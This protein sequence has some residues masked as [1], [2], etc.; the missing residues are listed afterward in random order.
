MGLGGIFIVTNCQL[1]LFEIWIIVAGGDI[2]IVFSTEEKFNQ[3][4][5]SSEN[6][7]EILSKY[8]A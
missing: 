2:Q 3:K 6:I 4:Q 5:N 8:G 7:F 1:E